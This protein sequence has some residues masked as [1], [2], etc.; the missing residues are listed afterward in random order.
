[1]SDKDRENETPKTTN[2]RPPEVEAPEL[3][4]VMEG[5][6][7]QDDKNKSKNEKS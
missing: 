5:Y 4:P 3:V 6:T 7:E 1:M 2:E